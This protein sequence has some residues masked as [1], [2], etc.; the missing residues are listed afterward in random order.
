MWSNADAAGMNQRVSPAEPLAGIEPVPMAVR[1]AWLPGELRATL[2]LAGPLVL[3]NIAQSLIPAT[4]VILLGR[5]G[6]Q[7]LA[8]G[9]L[10][11]NLYNG[12]VIFGAGMVSAASPMIARALG[13]RTRAVRDVRRSV[14]QAIWV[15]VALTGPIWAMLWNA[16]AIL[17]GLG[18]D[19]F[20]SAQAAAMLR[21]MMFGILPL[22]LYQVLK[23]FVSATGSPGWSFLVGGIAVL[24]NAILNYGLIF[25]HFGLPRLG[26]FGAGLGSTISNLILGLGLLLV[27]LRH[28]RFRRFHL[29]G[30]FWHADWL[31][32]R[33]IA[34]LGLPIA[35]TLA[36]E[37]TFFNA[38]IILMGMLGTNELAAHAVANQINT[39]YFQIPSALGLAATIRVGRA[40]GA[41]DR[42]AIGRAGWTSF[43]V[44]MAFMSLSAAAMLLAPRLL[45][46]LFFDTN[47]T[48][49]H[50]VN[51]AVS[52]LA[53]GA[54]FQF[55]DG[56]QAVAAGMLRGLH[57]TTVPMICATFC[58]WGVGFGTAVALAFGMHLGGIGVWIGLAAGLWSAALLLM[59]RWSLQERIAL[60]NTL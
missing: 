50:V 25:G 45:V 34:R 59:T 38:A 22:F 42:V 14:R 15:A 32:F 52:F 26:L 10:G 27:A 49:P 54:V 36:M 46:S 43:A 9:I 53:I 35:I 11:V 57:D 56:G 4:D 31:R 60:A 3:T 44:T 8:A 29:F 23:G 58:Y 7:A 19:P 33:Q 12:C 47:T 16:E 20:L 13:R 21:P 48:P 17:R 41:G 24:S 6:P 28:R 51:L 55:A 2:G 39:L 1:L 30:N 5:A 18:Q 40:Y 37:T